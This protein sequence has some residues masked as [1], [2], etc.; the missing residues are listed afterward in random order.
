MKAWG[1][2]KDRA[3]WVKVRAVG[4]VWSWN[5]PANCQSGT[6]S[7]GGGDRLSGRV[8]LRNMWEKFTVR[9]QAWLWILVFVLS[10]VGNSLRSFEIYSI[11]FLELSEIFSQ[12]SAHCSLYPIV[13]HNDYDCSN[14]EDVCL[15]PQKD[16][17]TR[18][19]Y[20]RRNQKGQTWR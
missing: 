19:H 8:R 7:V 18:R 17:L 4:D 16:A 14:A 13:T 5:V 1:W 12:I 10:C 9:C 3:V 2:I 15:K 20:C 6:N 11:L